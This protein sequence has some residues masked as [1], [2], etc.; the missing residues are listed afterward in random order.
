MICISDLDFSF[1]FFLY[2]FRL[3]VAF[4]PALHA[5]TFQVPLLY[6]V[7]KFRVQCFASYHLPRRIDQVIWNQLFF[8]LLHRV[9]EFC[10]ICQAMPE[11]V[12][13]PRTFNTCII[14]MQLQSYY[15]VSIGT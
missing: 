9:F 6:R 5:F 10:T 15:N 12:I 3:I 14:Y 7:S 1:P 11:F 8:C 2:L 13:F 4:D